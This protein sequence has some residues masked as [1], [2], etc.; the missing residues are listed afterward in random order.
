MTRCIESQRQ[1]GACGLSVIGM[2]SGILRVGHKIWE[3]NA[4]GM[5]LVYG[6]EFQA[7]YDH[8]AML[9]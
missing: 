5:R 4:T 7:V 2:V 9:E 3:M 8:F 1:S 6:N